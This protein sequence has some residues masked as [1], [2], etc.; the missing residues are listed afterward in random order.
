MSFDVTVKPVGVPVATPII[1]PEPEA[2]RTAV[3]TQLPAPQSV[4][5]S[6]SASDSSAAAAN[7]AKSN[8]EASQN[9]SRK[10]LFDQA[11]AQIVY[12]SVDDNTREVI[13]QYPESWQ[14]K[15]RAYFREQDRA[16]VPS[17]TQPTNRVV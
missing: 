9:I 16:K 5:A 12:V 17:T 6:D 7:T 4:T 3:D 15:A 1:R 11:A 8:A 13:S 2:A 14:L 10:V